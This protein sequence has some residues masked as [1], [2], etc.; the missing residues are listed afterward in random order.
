MKKILFLAAVLIGVAFLVHQ[1]APFTVSAEEREVR[2][3]DARLTA[4]HRRFSQAAR[5]GGL[6]G[7][8]TTH[9]VASAAA[10]LDR[11]EREFRELKRRLVSE[12]GKR[13]AARLEERLREVRAQMR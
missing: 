1:Y 7:I 12:P 8:D 6:S 10:E 4:A 9:D 2:E 3:L 5:A 13:A 11:V